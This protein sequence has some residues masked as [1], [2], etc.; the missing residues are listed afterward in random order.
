MSLTCISLR[1]IL[2]CV[3]RQLK[4]TMPVQIPGGNICPKVQLTTFH[5]D[6]YYPKV[7][8]DYYWQAGVCQPAMMHTPQCAAW[9]NVW[10]WARQRDWLLLRPPPQE[11]RRARSMCANCRLISCD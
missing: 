7:S 2:R 8:K 1:M 3:A 11:I 9:D 4:S 10:Q 6:V 5:T